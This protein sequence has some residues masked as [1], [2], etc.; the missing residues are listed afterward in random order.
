[1]VDSVTLQL[2]P[3][4]AASGCRCAKD[5]RKR[6][7]VRK[8][9]G[10]FVL[11]LP[12]GHVVHV[13]HLV[14]SE[15]LPQVAMAFAEGLRLL[16]TKSFL[17]YDFAC[18]LARFLRNPVRARATE[19]HARLAACTFV[20]P[21]SHL[22]NHT[23]CLDPSNDT[24]YL[25]EVRK[26]AHPSLAGVN[27]EAQEQVFSWV[28]W[29]THTANPMTPAKHRAFFKVLVLRRNMRRERIT[30]PQRQ[31]LRLRRPALVRNARATVAPRSEAILHF[32]FGFHCSTASACW[33]RCCC[34]THV[35]RGD[36]C[37]SRR[38][39]DAQSARPWVPQKLVP[40][41]SRRQT[42]SPGAR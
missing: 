17:L 38:C 33:S 20:I 19:M 40:Q 30:T 29:L 14:G 8:Y 31:R 16:P 34:C 27:C 5:E 23:A 36:R 37:C 9:A 4:G 32:L 6:L 7:A 26:A 1:M 39:R 15:S 18:E 3:S 10:V 11:V 21:D 42:S 24:Y 41:S 35:L 25:P 22:R 28:K 13:S 2:E 12:C